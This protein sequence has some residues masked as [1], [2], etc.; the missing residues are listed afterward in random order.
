MN[1]FPAICINAVI[2][3][4]ISALS[5]CASP[6]EE[7]AHAEHV[8]PA[9][10]PADFISAVDDLAS[11][12][13]A[14]AMNEQSVQELRDIIGWLPELAAQTDLVKAEW[15]QVHEI[16]MTLSRITWE[17]ADVNR[18]TVDGD[19]RRLRQLADRAIAVDRY[20]AFEEKV[21]HNA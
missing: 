8:I 15:D 11:R 9:H 14:R 3:F 18:D 4:S 17:S 7:D 2:I 1:K 5:G 6:S 10:K 12:I 19:L 21:S 20:N 13:D 16:S